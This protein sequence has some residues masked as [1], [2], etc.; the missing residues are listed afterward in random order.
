M[1]ATTLFTIVCTALGGGCGERASAD[2]GAAV[3]SGRES[4]RPPGCPPREENAELTLSPVHSSPFS[5]ERSPVGI[6]G[7]QPELLLVTDGVSA[8]LEVRG[9]DVPSRWIPVPEPVNAVT[10][11]PNGFLAA[12]D[13]V[14]Y[15][16]DSGTLSPTSLGRVPLRAGRIV[17]VAGDG[18]TIWAA[19]SVGGRGALYASQVT[20]PPSWRRIDLPSAAR[21]QALGRGAV[22]A[23]MM[24]SPHMVI[25]FDASLRATAQATPPSRVG[26]RRAAPDRVVT[27]GMLALDC[28]RALQVTADLRSEQRFFHLYDTTG[29]LRLVRSRAIRQP[30]GF[31]AA[32]PGERLMLGIVDRAGGREAVL[33]RWSWETPNI[34]ERRR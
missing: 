9:K 11:V 33:F 26:W 22:A 21:L 13:T 34:E 19:T 20:G 27:Q 29:G 5:G 14:I 32:F 7:R 10:A 23:A 6:T 8:G 15:L 2:A 28:G 12:S 1:R 3:E 16:L 25:V 4:S 17:S 30:V 31:A 24:A 18:Q